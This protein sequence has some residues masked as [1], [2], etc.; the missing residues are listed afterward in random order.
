M[1]D[2]IPNID[3]QLYYSIIQNSHNQRMFQS[4]ALDLHLR[5]RL[6]LENEISKIDTT[7]LKSL[8]VDYLLVNNHILGDE[9]FKRLVDS[10]KVNPSHFDFLKKFTKNY[11]FHN[12]RGWGIFDF[13]LLENAYGTHQPMEIIIGYLL[14]SAF[15][16]PESFILRLDNWKENLTQMGSLAERAKWFDS[17]KKKEAA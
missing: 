10:R 4:I 9:V 3:P 8:V 11:I 6:P 2:N 16:S 12:M 1:Q 5:F 7:Q 15:H 17:D 13:Y 14:D